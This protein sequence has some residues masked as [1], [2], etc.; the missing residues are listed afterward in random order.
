MERPVSVIE[1]VGM[2]KMHESYVLCV[3]VYGNIFEK[4]MATMTLNIMA[5]QEESERPGGITFNEAAFLMLITEC[6][7]FSDED[8]VALNHTIRACILWNLLEKPDMVK[9][10]ESLKDVLNLRK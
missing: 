2:K 6:E 4:Q 10:I 3:E 7:E 5:L 1:M 8:N 9:E